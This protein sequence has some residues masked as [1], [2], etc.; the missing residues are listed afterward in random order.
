MVKITI[1]APQGWGKGWLAQRI[2]DEV[3]KWKQTGVEIL[4]TDDTSS[5]VSPNST[6]AVEVQIKLV[7][8]IPASV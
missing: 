7:H 6:A 3:S 1:E 2:A 5:V 4:D 8:V